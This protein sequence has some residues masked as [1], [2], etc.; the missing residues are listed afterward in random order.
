[1]DGYVG[2]PAFFDYNDYFTSAEAG[3]PVS[4]SST[5][6]LKELALVDNTCRWSVG[7]EPTGN[8]PGV[9]FTPPTPTPIPPTAAPELGSITGYVYNDYNGNDSRDGGEP[10][11]GGAIVKLGR[12]ACASSGAGNR[13]SGGDGGFIFTGLEAGTYCVTVE[14]DNSCGAWLPSGATSRTVTIDEGE[15]GSAGNFGFSKH[16]CMLLLP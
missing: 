7:F 15:A 13:S 14:L 2:E 1:V 16:I 6:P 8:E 9:C 5:Y 4:G 10:G 12:G 3:S 11:I